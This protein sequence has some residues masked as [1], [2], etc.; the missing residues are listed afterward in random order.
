MEYEYHSVLLHIIDTRPTV[1]PEQALQAVM[2][3][4][5]F[6]ITSEFQIHRAA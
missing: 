4:F 1:M 3:N 6:H 2:D 5:H